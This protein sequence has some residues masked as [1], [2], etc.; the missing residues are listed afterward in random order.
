MSI[1]RFVLNSVSQPIGASDK[2]RES[3][4]KSSSSRGARAV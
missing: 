3:E 2:R 1:Y 4:S